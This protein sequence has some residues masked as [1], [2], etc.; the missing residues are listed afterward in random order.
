MNKSY[1]KRIDERIKLSFNEGIRCNKTYIIKFSSTDLSIQ[2]K[3]AKLANTS[4]EYYAYGNLVFHFI[5]GYL[6]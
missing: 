5:M 2:I 6:K 3:Y 4:A 1:Y